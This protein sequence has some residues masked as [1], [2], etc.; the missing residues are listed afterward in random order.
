MLPLQRSARR[1]FADLQL[2]EGDAMN[3]HD[4]AILEARATGR[5]VERIAAQFR[6]TPQAINRVLDA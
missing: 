6:T 1:G 3:D 4:A 2:G 5:S